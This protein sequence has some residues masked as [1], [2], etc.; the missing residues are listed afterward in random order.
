MMASKYSGGCNIWWNSKIPRKKSY[1]TKIIALSLSWTTAQ[2]QRQLL[3]RIASLN[4]FNVFSKYSLRKW[5][6]SYLITDMVLQ[7]MIWQVLIRS[8]I[9][10]V[11]MQLH[12]W[13]LQNPHYV[14]DLRKR[15]KMS[16]RILKQNWWSGKGYEICKICTKLVFR[17]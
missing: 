6:T 5:R 9:R 4:A 8:K 10:L 13:A 16:L 11:D 7:L 2:L 12:K 15:L 1:A 17:K 14:L 3:P